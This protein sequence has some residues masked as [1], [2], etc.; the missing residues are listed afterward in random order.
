MANNVANSDA[1][2]ISTVCVIDESPVG[3]RRNNGSDGENE[4]NDRYFRASSPLIH[5]HHALV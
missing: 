2:E 5:T 4:R 3:R 1:D